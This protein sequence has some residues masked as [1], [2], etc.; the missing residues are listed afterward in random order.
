MN[1]YENL[2]INWSQ[3]FTNMLLFIYIWSPSNIYWFIGIRICCQWIQMNS[4]S[5]T[6]NYSQYLVQ[7]SMNNPKGKK[8]TIRRYLILTFCVQ[9]KSVV[10]WLKMCKLHLETA[11]HLSAGLSVL[12]ERNRAMLNAQT[13]RTRDLGEMNFMFSWLSWT[14]KWF[15]IEVGDIYFMNS[16]FF[17]VSLSGLSTERNETERRAKTDGMGGRSEREREWYINS[18]L[19]SVQK[20]LN[21]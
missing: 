18:G 15:S 16:M 7:H 10:I 21:L 5:I 9:N 14:T 4:H 20:S 11:G 8:T 12:S 19:N 1:I 3:F 6:F 17:S 2:Q 13:D